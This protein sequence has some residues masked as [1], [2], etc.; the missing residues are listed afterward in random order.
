MLSQSRLGATSVSIPAVTLARW[1]AAACSVAPANAPA[2]N[3]WRSAWLACALRDCRATRGLLQPVHRVHEVD[4]RFFITG[5]EI[6]RA[7]L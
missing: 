1:T 6:G 4:D 2:P 3:R 5:I 7:T